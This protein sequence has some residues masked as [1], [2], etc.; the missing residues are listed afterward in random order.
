MSNARMAPCKNKRG[1]ASR[2]IAQAIIKQYQPKSA[3]DIQDTLRDIFSPMVEAMLVLQKTVTGS[4][5]VNRE[6]TFSV[7][8][9]GK[10]GSALNERFPYD[11][12][13]QRTIASGESVA[14]MHGQHI[15]I[16]DLPDGA[17]YTTEREAKQEGYTTRLKLRKP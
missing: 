11:G 10:D 5:D 1:E 6:F 9:S 15:L 3:E 12:D 17:R 16:T 8:F 14:L 7:T 2:A 13:R 4:G